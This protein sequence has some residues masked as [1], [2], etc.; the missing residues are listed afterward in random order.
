LTPA[1]ELTPCSWPSELLL[2]LLLVNNKFLVGGF[3][4]VTDH[5]LSPKPFCSLLIQLQLPYNTLSTERE[6]ER[7]RDF[8]LVTSDGFGRDSATAYKS[9]V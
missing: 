3:I 8:E 1:S 4:L 5:I 9:L 6:R 7:E 2:L